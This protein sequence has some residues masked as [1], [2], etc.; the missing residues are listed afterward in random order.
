METP[1]LIRKKRDGLVLSQAEIFD[2]VECYTRGEIPDYQASAL[3]MAVYFRGMDRRETADL[4]EAML[5]SGRVLDFSALPAPK[6]DKHSTGGVGDKTSL[7]IAP[8]AAAAGV[9]VPMISG[10]GLG[11]TGG[12]LDKL[13]AIPGFSPRLSYQ[14]FQRILDKC[15]L[16]LGAATEEFAP[17][18]RKLYALRDVTATVESIPL[19][20][21]SIMSKKLAEGI[22]GLVLDVKTGAGAFMQELDHARALATSLVNTGEAHGKRVHAL[23]TDMSQPLGNAVG[24]A[25]EVIE[26]VEALKGHGP[27]DLVELCRELTAHM[28]LLGN[29]TDSLEEARALYDSAIASGNALDRFARVVEE[30]GGN[31]R[32]LEDY[33]LLPQAQFED[34]VVAPEDGYISELEARVMGVA[35]MVLGAGR[36]RADAIIDP[37][38]GLVFEKKVGDAVRA[39]ER[40]CILYSN[41]RSRLPW[42]LDM[43]REAIVISPDPVS[44]PQL[45][46][47]RVL[48]SEGAVPA[49]ERVV[50]L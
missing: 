34:A 45:I 4:T 47:E 29:L 39:G 17:A 26:S 49:P 48:H 37:A 24:N 41:D 33:S 44:P 1:E 46:L 28:L 6:V 19:I 16:A 31:P 15:G 43:I 13:E 18:D 32:A 20:T 11:H 14:E 30:Q 23:I 50:E 38:V 40:I 22:D 27:R 7:I 8:A 36:E 10:R 2:F 12:T 9:L 35:S 3:L 21:A 42:A 5:R 25:L